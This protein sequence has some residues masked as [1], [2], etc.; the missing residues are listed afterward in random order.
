MTLENTLLQKL[1]RW[2]FPAGTRQ[3]LDAADAGWSVTVDAECADTVGC[4]VWEVSLSRPVP[5]TDDVQERAGRV[6]QRVTGLLEP[7]KL[8]E[9]DAAKGTALL[10]SATPKSTADG[11]A[12]Y[13][14]L[15]KAGGS[16]NVRRYESERAGGKRKQVGYTLTHEALAKLADDLTV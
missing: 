12:Y 16:A 8:L 5:L 7:L 11:L 1:S 4:R 3:T 15:L 13:E 9:L 6:A 2:R 10:R 14:I